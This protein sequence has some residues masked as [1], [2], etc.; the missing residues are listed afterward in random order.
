MA[1]VAVLVELPVQVAQLVKA[2]VMVQG[3]QREMARAPEHPHLLALQMERAP[4]HLHPLV[5]AQAAQVP[6]QALLR[7]PE[8][9]MAL[10]QEP[11]MVQVQELG[12]A[13]AMLPE[14][15][16]EMVQEMVQEMALLGRHHLLYNQRS[17]YLKN[18][19]L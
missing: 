19:I 11:E 17:V 9:G 2:L 5:Q 15:V 12:M 6:A 14:M 1:P 3:Q 16:P 7:A 13:L 4:E 18:K 10:Q 8:V